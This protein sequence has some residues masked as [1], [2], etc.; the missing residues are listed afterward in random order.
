M[1]QYLENYWFEKYEYEA[2]F[3]ASQWGLPVSTTM[4]PESVAAMFDDENIT[5]TSLRIVWNNK[6][7]AFGKRDILPEEEVHNL[8]TGYMEAEYGTYEYDKEKGMEK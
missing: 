6:R 8:G 4:K 3:T 1:A 7:D 2:I 5:L